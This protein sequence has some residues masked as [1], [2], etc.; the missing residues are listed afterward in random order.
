MIMENKV[1]SK[2]PL[3]VKVRKAALL[4]D[5]SERTI[6]NLVMRGKLEARGQNRLRRITMTSIRRYAEEGNPNNVDIE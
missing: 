6:R 3:L 5:V 4:L 1:E 2:E